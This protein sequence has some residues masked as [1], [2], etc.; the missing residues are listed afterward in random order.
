MWS[1]DSSVLEFVSDAP[2]DVN[3]LFTSYGCR[4]PSHMRPRKHWSFD[5]HALFSATLSDILLSTHGSMMGSNSVFGVSHTLL[6]TCYLCCNSGRNQRH[7]LDEG[8]PAV[9]DGQA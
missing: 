3:Y 7:H 1:S 9:G 4:L 2:P 8:A 6:K 5:M